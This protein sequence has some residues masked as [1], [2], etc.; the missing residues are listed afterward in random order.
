VT[1]RDVGGPVARTKSDVE[2]GDLSTDVIERQLADAVTAGQL[3]T[4]LIIRL[5]ARVTELERVTA[6]MRGHLQNLGVTVW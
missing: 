3:T 1:E 5:E 4:E 2:V 6:R